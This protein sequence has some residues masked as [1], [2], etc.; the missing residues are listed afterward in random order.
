ME[1]SLVTITRL[2]SNEMWQKNVRDGTK[3]KTVFS[4]V[5]LVLDPARPTN[6]AIKHKIKIFLSG[7]P[8]SN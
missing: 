7:K 2:I 6:L 8:V 4:I 5:A 1:I 3:K